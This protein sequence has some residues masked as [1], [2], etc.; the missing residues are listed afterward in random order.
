M[1]TDRDALLAGIVADPDADLPRLVFADWLEETGH[2]ANCAR[3]EYIRLA[4]ELWHRPGGRGGSDARRLEVLNRAF[5]DEWDVFEAT[6]AQGDLVQPPLRDRGFVSTVSL[7]GRV[8]PAALRELSCRQPVQSLFVSGAFGPRLPPPESMILLALDRLIVHGAAEFGDFVD[9]YLLDA[10]L[11]LLRTLTINS[12]R[13]EDGDVV[14]LVRVLARNPTLTRLENL[15]LT[16]NPLTDHAAHTLAAADWPGTLHRLSIGLSQI[17]N[18]G[19]EV[20]F[21]RFGFEELRP[22][23]ALS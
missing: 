7:A 21:R 9:H 15:D 6:L 19:L 22:R 8:L 2:P 5:R 20:L 17:T 16:D 14:R 12:C 1:Q 11:P 10:R 4:I 23:L 3:A 13:L 18:A